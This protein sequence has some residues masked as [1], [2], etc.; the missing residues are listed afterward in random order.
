MI[1]SLF[2]FTLYGLLCLMSLFTRAEI[3]KWVDDNGKVHYSD[4]KQSTAQAA[5]GDVEEIEIKDRFAIKDIRDVPPIRYEKET[6]SHPLVFEKLTIDTGK[7]TWGQVS[8]G[9]YC[10]KAL[11]FS[12]EQEFVD[13]SDPVISREIAEEFRKN[14]YAADA[15]GNA[16]AGIGGSYRLA[17]NITDIT[18]HICIPQYTGSRNSQGKSAVYLEVKWQ[19][20]DVVSGETLFSAT[21]EGSF[22]NWDKNTTKVNENVGIAVLGALKIALHRLMAKPQFVVMLEPKDL[23]SIAQADLNDLN[24]NLYF[25]NGSGR[26]QKAANKIKESAVTVVTGSGHGSGVVVSSDGYVLTNAHVI[27]QQ[28]EVGILVGNNQYTAS[29]IRVEKVRDVA[30]LKLA[31]VPL[32]EVAKISQSKPD[33]GAE[34]F[35]VGTPLDKALSHTITRGIYSAYRDI[36]GLSYFQ[37]DAAINPGNSGGPVF[38]EYGEVVA[39]TVAGIFTRDGGGLSVNYLIPVESALQSLKIKQSDDEMTGSLQKAADNYISN[40]NNNADSGKA[41]T[42][43]EWL[44]S[45]KAWLDEPVF[46]Y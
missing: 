7:S 5:S 2:R 24:V 25:G 28:K 12:R 14:G 40:V 22:S 18:L 4:N 16:A 23:S 36:R 17:A 32:L 3:Y 30:L 21:T 19:L 34:L 39:L 31:S 15:T 41:T 11:P 33:V 27:G 8:T 37:T 13:L 1:G 9:K 26:F 35:V 42:A 43:N 38:D 20:E 45:L 29:V 6:A 46:S 44:N 10:S